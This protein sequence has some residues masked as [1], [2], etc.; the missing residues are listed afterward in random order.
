MNG[1]RDFRRALPGVIET[2][3]LRAAQDNAGIASSAVPTLSAVCGGSPAAEIDSRGSVWTHREPTSLERIETLTPRR[4]PCSDVSGSGAR[5]KGRSEAAQL[6]K[7]LRTGT[8]GFPGAEPGGGAHFE[9][10]ELLEGE[11]ARPR[12]LHPVQ[13]VLPAPRQDRLSPLQAWRSAAPETPMWLMASQSTGAMDTCGKRREP[14]G[15]SGELKFYNFR[16]K[17]KNFNTFAG[18][19]YL[20]ATLPPL[21]KTDR[22]C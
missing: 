5:R 14:F 22:R 17:V 13:L 6:L 18:T 9:A 10:V 20:G 11:H 8:L 3:A 7:R 1:H 19:K 16:A 15:N 12:C 4:C 2:P 21:K